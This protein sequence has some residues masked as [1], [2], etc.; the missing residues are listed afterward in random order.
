MPSKFDFLSPG[1]VLREV[2]LSV[3]PA[4]VEEEG[5][6]IIGRTRKGPAM[7]P[8]KVRNLEDFITIFGTPVPGGSTLEGDVWRNGNT[9]GPTYASYAAQA[10]LASQQSPVTMVRLLGDQHDNAT[11]AGYAGWS[12]GSASVDEGQMGGAYGLFVIEKANVGQ[13]S[14]F[15]FTTDAGFSI[16]DLEDDTNPGVNPCVIQVI[17]RTDNN[18]NTNASGHAVSDGLKIEIDF[19]DDTPDVAAGSVA[20]ALD[21][22]ESVA[23]YTCGVNGYSTAAEVMAVIKIALDTALANGDIA[24]FTVKDPTDGTLVIT[25]H[26]TGNVLFFSNK[27]NERD[28][29]KVTAGIIDDGASASNTSTRGGVVAGA[30]FA[31]AATGT[32]ALAAVFYQKEEKGSLVLYGTPAGGSVATG[33][34][35]ILMKSNAAACGFTLRVLN[36]ANAKVEDISFNFDRNSDGYIRSVC[37]TNPQLTHATMVAADNQ[38][39]YW[40]GESF[41]RHLSSKLSSDSLAAGDAYAVLLPLQEK[42]GAA[43][44]NWSYMKTGM[45][46]AHS[47]WVFAQDQGT[48]ADFQPQDKQKLFRCISL[49]EGEEV[50]KEIVIAIAELKLPTNPAVDNYS[51]F[52]LRILGMTDGALLEEYKLCNLNPA[53]PNY[54][55][56]KVGDMYQT[57]DRTN[58]RYRMYGNHPN[59]SNYIRVE[60]DEDINEGSIPDSTMLPFGFYGPVRPSGWQHVSGSGDNVYKLAGG[61]LTNAFAVGTPANVANG[62]RSSVARHGSGADASVATADF[63]FDELTAAAYKFEYPKLQ[64]RNSGSDGYTTNPYKTYFGVRPVISA[65]STTRDMD[66]VDYVRRWNNTNYTLTSPAAGYEHSFFFSL[67]DV[68]IDTNLDVVFY[69]SGSRAG[70]GSYTATV[71][72]SNLLTKGVKQFVMPLF[73]GFDGV[74]ISEKEPFRNALLAGS[75]TTSYQLNS[76]NKAIDS[77]SDPEIAPCNLL[78]IP[79]V[80]KPAITNRLMNVAQNRKDALAII[81]LEGDYTPRTESTESASSRRGLVSTAVANLKSRNLNSSYACAFYPWVQIT[82]NLSAGERVW[83][84]P[85]VAAVGAMAQSQAR[86]E[87]WFAPAGFNRGGLGNLGG[88]Q[89]PR[90][91]QARQRLDVSERDDLYEVNINPIATFP[92]EGVVIFG[93]KTLQVTP[94][95]LDRINVR[96]LMIFL[97]SKVGH[98]AR[99]LLFDQNVASTWSRFTGQVEPLLA[100]VQS[101]FGITEYKVVLDETTTTPDLIDRNIMYAKIFLK[102]ARAIEFIVVDFV[103]TR[104][105]AEFA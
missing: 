96:R 43:A 28:Q 69:L 26:D 86:S 8:I 34:A 57:W 55:G 92:N 1:V 72:T 47:G 80:N 61:E 5:P 40:L 16:S 102:P 14:S 93:Q 33:S 97:K 105:G 89:G 37:N 50:Q 99:N 41:E 58:K 60:V 49:H 88:A 42:N 52:T 21:G 24:D 29:F 90:V 84:P 87:L 91:V 27:D 18:L 15:T 45:K 56:R 76:V 4:D 32:G 104:S 67:D 20:R 9:A 10:W 68:V 2:D 39:N 79:G 23:K 25:N 48:A 22:T 54:L 36:T 98:I 53:S 74:D 59:V 95:A 78:M 6:V 62:S 73:G 31:V 63:I 35:G 81:D 51:T 19:D 100:D 82:D 101:R 46:E 65:N 66:Y 30:T 17:R 75:D 77:I 3:L 70:G 94:S 103:I 13:G 12:M 11:A 38:K 64:L 85:S 83:V 7:K 71:G 44:D